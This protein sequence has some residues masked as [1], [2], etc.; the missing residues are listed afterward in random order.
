MKNQKIRIMNTIKGKLR[1]NKII[2]IRQ[3]KMMSEKQHLYKIDNYNT[4]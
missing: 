3:R 2:S 1:F 4:Q